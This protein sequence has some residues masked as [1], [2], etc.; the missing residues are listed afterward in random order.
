VDLNQ[1]IVFFDGDCGFCNKTIQ[2]VLRHEKGNSLRF[3]SLQSSFAQ[4]FFKAKNF[5]EPDLSTFYFF[6]GSELHERS[7]AALKLIPNLKWYCKPLSI[8]WFFPKKIRD[9][10][11][12]FIAKRRSKLA[13]GFCLIPT[14]EERKR[15]FIN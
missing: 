13:K 2:F 15:F 6:D 3:S 14:L 7:T 10:F 4:D 8:G 5:P 11:Y 12:N 9:T 1:Q